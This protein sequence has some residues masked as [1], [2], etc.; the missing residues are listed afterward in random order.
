MSLTM[1]VAAQTKEQQK[2]LF[3]RNPMNPEITSPVPAKDYMNM[4]YIP[5]YAEKNMAMETEEPQKPLF[6]RNPMNSDITSPVPA[7]DNMGMDY[8]PVYAENNMEMDM[9]PLGSV[10]IDPVTV[11]NM[12]VR[13]AIATSSVLSHKIR[14][15]GRVA[16]DEERITRLHPKTDGWIEKLFVDKTGTPVKKGTMLLSI[17]SPQLVTSAQEYLLA[18]KSLKTLENSPFEDIS[19]GAKQMAVITVDAVLKVIKLHVMN[20]ALLA[21]SLNGSSLSRFSSATSLIKDCMTG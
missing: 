14:A 18:L 4:D 13:T 21:E 10:Q 11:Q 9:A 19:F 7:K 17:Y 3:Y 12:G 15:M 2:P 1:S 20:S 16:Y 5:V 6:Y 8:V